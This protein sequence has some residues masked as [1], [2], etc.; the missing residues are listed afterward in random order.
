MI[1][2]KLISALALILT[3]LLV[4]FVS[5]YYPSTS[6]P[7]AIVFGIVAIL[8]FWNLYRVASSKEGRDD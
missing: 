6:T 3:W 8:L 5:H 7:L 4:M 1:K 2:V